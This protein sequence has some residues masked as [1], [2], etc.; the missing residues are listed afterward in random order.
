MDYS[1][2]DQ[3]TVR[4]YWEE[5][6]EKFES[7]DEKTQS[8]ALYDFLTMLRTDFV[9]I[10]PGRLTDYSQDEIRGAVD[11]LDKKYTEI[12]KYFQRHDIC[13][14]LPVTGYRKSFLGSHPGVANMYGS[15]L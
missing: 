10:C 15:D 2:I 1:K 6:H 7:G 9:T 12:V 13:H 8:K 4:K 3:H 14:H 11:Y 5:L